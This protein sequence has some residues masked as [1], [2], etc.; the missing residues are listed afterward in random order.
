MYDDANSE[1]RGLVPPPHIHGVGTELNRGGVT[2]P[3]LVGTHSVIMQ[4][5]SSHEIMVMPFGFVGRALVY[6]AL[7]R[8][9]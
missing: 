1:V 6:F 7:C 9:L 5:T 4:I 2:A 8:N 3:H